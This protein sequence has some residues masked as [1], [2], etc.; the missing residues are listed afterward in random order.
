V[1]NKPIYFTPAAKYCDKHVCFVCLFVCLSVRSHI[2]KNHTSKFH[3]IICTRYLRSWFGPAVLFCTS[4]FVD[5]VMCSYN[6]P[7]QRRRVCFV[8]FESGLFSA[9]YENMTSS[10]KPEVRNAFR[11]E[12]EKRATPHVTRTENLVTRL[13]FLRYANRQTD[14]QTNIE[15]RWSQYFAEILASK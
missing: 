13:L 12:E 2:L 11:S 9:L 8:Q 6:G 15:T 4:G 5:D 14:K 7:N 1:P 10:T 3:Q